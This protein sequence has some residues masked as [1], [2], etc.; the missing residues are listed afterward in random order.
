VALPTP[1]GT[2]SAADRAH[3]AGFY[4]GIALEGAIVAPIDGGVA[5]PTLE[6]GGG[7]D[8]PTLEY[9]GGVAPP[10]IDLG[11]ATDEPSFE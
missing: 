6:Y 9:G 7:V 10:T 5:L 1:D 3:S 4:A 2:I 11:G 8:A